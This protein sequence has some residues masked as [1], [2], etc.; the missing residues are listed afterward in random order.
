MLNAND[1]TLESVFV[2]KSHIVVGVNWS[3]DQTETV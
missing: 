3:C 2:I 1:A